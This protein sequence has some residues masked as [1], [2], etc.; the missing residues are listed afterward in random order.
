MTT[1]KYLSDYH[2][3]EIHDYVMNITKSK[4]E[5]N[6]E[7]RPHIDSMLSSLKNDSH[8]PSIIDKAIHLFYSLIKNHYFFDGNKRTAL[9]CTAFFLYVNDLGKYT[10]IFIHNCANT[11]ISVADN[12]YSKDDLKILFKANLA[13]TELGEDVQKYYEL[14]KMKTTAYSQFSAGFTYLLSGIDLL[15]NYKEEQIKDTSENWSE[16]DIAVFNACIDYLK[17]YSRKLTKLHLGYNKA[18]DEAIGKFL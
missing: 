17:D 16:G 12:T 18:V 8:Y 6:G 3:L 15:R 11:A 10:S 5:N 14:E 9:A 2:I 13:G 4:I 1:I 7:K